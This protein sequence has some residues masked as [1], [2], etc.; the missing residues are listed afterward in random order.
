MT[1]A[2]YWL[3]VFGPDYEI[4]GTADLLCRDDL[5]AA[6]FAFAT[7]SPY[8]HELWSQA[9]FLGRFEM[10]LSREDTD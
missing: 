5:E 9:G 3:V 8:G 7:S 1:S 4:A 6:M 2:A 10:S